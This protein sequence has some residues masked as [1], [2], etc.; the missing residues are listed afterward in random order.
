MDGFNSRVLICGQRSSKQA[1][2]VQRAGEKRRTS[3]NRW[4]PLTVPRPASLS[5][6]H[7][8]ARSFVTGADRVRSGV[9]VMVATCN[10][11]GDLHWSRSN[12]GKKPS[13]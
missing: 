11:V 3:Y 9:L 4:V 1:G 5:V 6:D 7:M 2:V 12:L 8:L 13:C 10:G